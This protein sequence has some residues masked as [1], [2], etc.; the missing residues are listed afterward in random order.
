MDK[1]NLG[2]NQADTLAS[3]NNL[4]NLYKSQEYGKA[5]P[6][7]EECFKMNKVVFGETHPITLANEQFS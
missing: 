3:M 4:A 7:Y 2:D 6:L 1:A 5:L